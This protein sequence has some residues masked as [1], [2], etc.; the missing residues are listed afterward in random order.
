MII[1]HMMTKTDMYI[2]VIFWKTSL[3]VYYDMKNTIFNEMRG[4]FYKYIPYYI[5]IY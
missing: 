4:M 2:I 5:I 3:K 1:I